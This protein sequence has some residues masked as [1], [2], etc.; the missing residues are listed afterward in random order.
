LNNPN[1]EPLEKVLDQYDLT[2]K[3]IKTETY[4][5]KKAVWWVETDRGR[6]VLKKVSSSEQTLKFAVRAPASAQQR[7][8]FGA[9]HKNKER[10]GLYGG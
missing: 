3:S 9:H 2:V 7:H 6:M 1:R 8:S 4:K 10:H 5:D